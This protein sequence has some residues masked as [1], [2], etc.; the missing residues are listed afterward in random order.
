MP[1]IAIED[2]DHMRESVFFDGPDIKRKLSRFWILLDPRLDHRG[3]RRGR[4]LDGNGHRRH[5]RRTADD[6][7]PR[8]DARGRPRRPCE[9]PAVDRPRPRRG[10]G[11]HRDRLPDRGV[12]RQPGGRR[13]EPPGGRSGQ[14]AADR[15]RRRAG[16]RGGRFGGPRPPR[17]LRHASRRRDRH[18]PRAATDGR[19]SDGR[20]E[21]VR[22]GGGRV[23]PLRARTSRRSW[24]P[25]S[26]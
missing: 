9:P 7:D 2:I 17:H 11:G 21:R 25:A 3:G 24:R 6:P 4:R 22:G 19:R 12:R 14:P 23:V 1:S 10:A 18:L 15:P 5:D 16:D 20:V 8:H 13:H 26:S